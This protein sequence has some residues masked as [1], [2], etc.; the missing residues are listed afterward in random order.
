M[1]LNI[2]RLERV[3]KEIL[4]AMDECVKVSVKIVDE[5]PVLKKERMIE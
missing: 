4:E 3:I 5:S 1:E 2:E